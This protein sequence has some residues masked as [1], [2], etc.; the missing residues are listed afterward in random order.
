MASNPRRLIDSLSDAEIEVL[1]ERGRQI[2][3]EGWT[4]EHDAEHTPRPGR[5]EVGPL[6]EAA[7]CY[8]WGFT[9]VHNLNWPWAIS[10]WKPKDYR[11][12]L[13]KAA[14]LLI[15]EIER[16][17]RAASTERLEQFRQRIEAARGS[18]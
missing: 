5:K 10:W 6:A 14:A 1:Y 2:H 18:A 12:N 15:A 17:D 7:S 11:R 9:G 4:L 16:L 3:V 13:V 8:V